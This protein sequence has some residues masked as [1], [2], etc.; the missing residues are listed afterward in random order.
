MFR[1]QLKKNHGMLFLFSRP[2]ILSFWMKNTL[3]PLDIAYIDSTGRI[4]DIQTMEPETL[5]SHPSKSEAQYALEMNKGWFTQQ[6]VGIGTSIKIPE[7]PTA[8]EN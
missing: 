3:I 8:E 7:C 5:I 6:N 4:I 1:K 2:Q